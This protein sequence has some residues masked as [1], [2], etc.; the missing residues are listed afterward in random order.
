MYENKVN[1]NLQVKE[2]PKENASYDF[3]SLITLDCVTRINKKHYL[4]DLLEE[5]KYKIRKNKKENVLNNDLELDTDSESYN[6]FE[7]ES[8][9]D[10]FV[11]IIS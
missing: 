9:S 4:Q 1:T 5:C 3:L 6:K 10:Y 8:E 11:L 2:V 7:G